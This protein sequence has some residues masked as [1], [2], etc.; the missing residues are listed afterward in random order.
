M[1]FSGVAHDVADTAGVF[2]AIAALPLLFP[3][4]LRAHRLTQRERVRPCAEQQAVRPPAEKHRRAV[5]EH[6]VRPEEGEAPRVV[7]LEDQVGAKAR[8][9]LPAL[10]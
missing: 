6:G 2:G 8:Q 4:A 9:V 3:D 7:G 5:A 1:F 10:A